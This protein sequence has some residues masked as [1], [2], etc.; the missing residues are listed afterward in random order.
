MASNETLVRS[1]VDPAEGAGRVAF[2]KM[3]GEYALY[4]DG[5]VVALVCDNLL[6]VK[7]TEAG[8]ALLGPVPEAAPR[9]A[10]MGAL[11]SR[12]GIHSM[13]GW[14]TRSA[15]DYAEW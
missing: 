5:K 15:T 8:R 10:V 13:K 7:P 11:P 3:F 1:I 2:R 12:V 14:T 6:Y 4:C 9:G